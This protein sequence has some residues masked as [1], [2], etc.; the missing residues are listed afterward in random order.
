MWV[1]EEDRKSFRVEIGLSRD[2]REWRRFSRHLAL[3]GS[4]N[5]A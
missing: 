4:N 2:G 1:E 5:V 3:I